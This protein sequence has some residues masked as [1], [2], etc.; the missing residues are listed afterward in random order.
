M[1]RLCENWWFSIATFEYQANWVDGS[2][3]LILSQFQVCDAHQLD[4]SLIILCVVRMSFSSGKRMSKIYNSK[5]LAKY[6]G[7]PQ[8]VCLP[9]RLLAFEGKMRELHGKFWDVWWNYDK[10]IS[11]GGWFRNPAP[12][13]RLKRCKLCG[14][15]HHFQLVRISQPSTVGGHVSESQTGSPWGLADFLL[16]LA[17]RMGRWMVTS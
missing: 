13:K 2:L 17:A 7:R 12:K 10:R 6:F 1:G 15:N 14:I 11:A 8:V 9:L 4:V 16:S 5:L 3:C